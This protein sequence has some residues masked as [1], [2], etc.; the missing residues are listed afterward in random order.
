VTA[1]WDL[2]G[3]SFLSNRLELFTLYNKIKQNTI[4]DGISVTKEK[5]SPKRPPS[6]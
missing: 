3:L 2:F 6:A 5:A 4:T 1:L